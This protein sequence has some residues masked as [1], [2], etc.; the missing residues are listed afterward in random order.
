MWGTI[1]WEKHLSL[2]GIAS[3]NTPQHAI[4]VCAIIISRTCSLASSEDVIASHDDDDAKPFY[5][6]YAGFTSIYSRYVIIILQQ[7][8]HARIN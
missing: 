8:M 4:Y 3:S 2:H 1:G 5:Q 6:P 7:P